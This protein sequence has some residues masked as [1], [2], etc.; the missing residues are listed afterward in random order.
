LDA[1]GLLI[2]RFWEGPTTMVPPSYG[3]GVSDAPA[4]PAFWVPASLLTV[5]SFPYVAVLSELTARSMVPLFVVKC[6]TRIVFP[7]DQLRIRSAFSWL[8]AFAP[9]S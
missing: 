7:D 1:L 6:L 2:V 5:M 3:F 8:P 9:R 4:V